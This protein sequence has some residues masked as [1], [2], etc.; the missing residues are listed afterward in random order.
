MAYQPKSYRKFLATG[1]AVA[2]AA[3][4]VAPAALA[5]E[6]VSFTDTDSVK[7]W[8]GDAIDYLVGKGAING[9]GNGIYDP[10][11]AITRAEA[12][13]VLALSLGLN[14]DEDAKTELTDATNHWASSF[15]AAI[16]DQKPGVIN[17]FTDGT[18]RP[19]QTITREQL[20]KMIVEAYGLTKDETAI[21]SFSDVSGWAQEYVYTL[22]SLGVVNG[23]S[24]GTFR[25]GNDVTRAEAAVFVHRTEVEEVRLEV[26]TSEPVVTSVS[27]VNAK[28]LQIKFNQPIDKD[29][30]I[31]N[32][33]TDNTLKS[34]VSVVAAN[35]NAEAI[36]SSNLN[37]S[38]S[39]DGK[40]LTITNISASE[41]FNGDYTVTVD[42]AKAFNGVTVKEYIARLSVNDTVAPTVTN[43]EYDAVSDQV[44]VT[45]SEAIKANPTVLRVNGTPVSFTNAN[46]APVT[47][48][49]FARPASSSTGSSASIYIAGA[50]DFNGNVLAAFNGSVTFT[51]DASA[52]GVKSF[53]QYDSNTLRVEFNKKLGSKSGSTTIADLNATLTVL[54]DAAPFTD[55]S[56]EAAPGDTTGTKFDIKFN[57]NT[58][59]GTG[60]NKDLTLLLASNGLVDLFGNNNPASTSTYKMVK[61]TVAPT[62][63]GTSVS[64]DKKTITV[65]FSEGVTLEDA[66]KFIVRRDGIATTGLTFTEDADDNKKINITKSD[67]TAFVAGN[68]SI[69]IE[70][71]AVADLVERNKNTLATTTATVSAGSS[72]TTDLVATVSSVVTEANTFEVS[73]SD[74]GSLKEVTTATALNASNYRLDGQALPANTD[75]Y[76]KDADK[77][78][79]V[80][81]LPAKSV[82]IGEV[83]TGTNAILSVSGVRSADGKTVVST[84]GTVT[85][86]DN[87]PATLTSATKSGNS[88]IVTFSEAINPTSL[89]ATDFEITTSTGSTVAT[90]DYTVIPVTGNTSQVQINFTT[91]PSGAITVKTAPAATLTLTD[92]NLLKVASGSQVVA[93]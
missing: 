55:Y 38:L 32:A 20:S 42:G 17:G 10:Q 49:T 80:I 27:A 11:T 72:T 41:Y 67:N 13:K 35:S 59:Y 14:V 3:T 88:V 48:L 83:G 74:N 15:I 61:D 71:S 60:N 92:S 76:F 53:T 51:R 26:E 56:I 23:Y 85:V 43:V 91:I 82:N 29:S 22:A 78:V 90:T 87:T 70:A 81:V 68:Y 5:A 57:S 65:T 24:N 46:T 28:E 93:N 1:V 54:K 89:N 37:G 9:R 64:S 25:P 44:K 12:A 75:I 6:Q 30:V 4:T 66:N 52:L 86:E 16:Q 73:F 7:E 40:T 50:E 69:R 31:V 18:F 62:V 47:E 19:D 8:A 84:S 33:G 2:V 21:V 39:S 58:L 34:A 79:V 36:T 45:L 77:Q 63:A